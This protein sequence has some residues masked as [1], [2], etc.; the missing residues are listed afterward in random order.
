MKSLLCV[1]TGCKQITDIKVN[2]SFVQLGGNATLLCSVDSFDTRYEIFKWTRG[3]NDTLLTFQGSSIDSKKFQCTTKH[4]EFCL[5]IY[6][7]TKQDV[8]VTYTFTCGFA[9]TSI[10]LHLKESKYTAYYILPYNVI[11]TYR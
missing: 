10:T 9:K 7:I 5:T 3:Q 8:N 1:F 6:N 2:S 11:N 4:L